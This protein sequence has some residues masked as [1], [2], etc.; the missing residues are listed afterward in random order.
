MYVLNT[1]EIINN[2]KADIINKIF[3]L[4]YGTTVNI[5]QQN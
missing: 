4:N 2:N 1:I 5:G 3:W